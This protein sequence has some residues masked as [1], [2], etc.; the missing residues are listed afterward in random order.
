MAISQRW[1][2]RG[3]DQ[4]LCVQSCV[5]DALP[6]ARPRNGQDRQC[7]VCSAPLSLNPG[8]KG[9]WIVWTCHGGCRP[10]VVR[11]GLEEKINAECLGAWYSDEWLARKNGQPAAVYPA[12][13]PAT[14]RAARRWYA[15]QKL[16]GQ[17]I[18]NASLLRMCMQAIAEG[19]GEVPGDWR[20][21]LP[22]TRA[23]FVALAKRA[24]IE[25]PHRHVLATNWFSKA[26][27]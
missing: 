20:A 14:E 12:R 9:M 4:K 23:E 2:A 19:D 25:K 10:E 17:K 13:D 26:T 3:F 6:L 5:R 15:A 21:L 11:A 24:G 22:A 16:I 27:T 1:C 7:P 18:T 8:T